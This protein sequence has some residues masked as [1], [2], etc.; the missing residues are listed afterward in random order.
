MTL[1]NQPNKMPTRKLTAGV[2]GG[3]TTSVAMGVLNAYSPELYQS[4]MHPGF[5]AGVATLIGGFI[6]YMT[7]NDFK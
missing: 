3:A 2:L 6:A 1:Q 4:L 7:K 5:E